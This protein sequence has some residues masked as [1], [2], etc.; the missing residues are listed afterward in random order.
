MTAERLFNSFIPPKKTLYPP[1]KK[2][3][4]GYAPDNGCEVVA[5]FVCPRWPSAAILDFIEPQIAPFDPQT[6]KTLA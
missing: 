2:Q 1:K 3:I 5:I 6:P 4:S